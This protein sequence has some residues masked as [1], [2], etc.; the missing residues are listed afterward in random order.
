M[1]KSAEDIRVPEHQSSGL[2]FHLCITYSGCKQ[3]CSECVSWAHSSEHPCQSSG[4]DDSPV[5]VFLE[6]TQ[7]PGYPGSWKDWVPPVPT[8]P[9]GVKAPS[10]ASPQGMGGQKD[11]VPPLLRVPGGLK[12]PSPASPKGT[13][14]RKRL[15]PG[16]LILVMLVTT[17]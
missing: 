6:G 14:S 17:F 4:L 3:T 5:P 2:K 11:W 15:G 16:G 13:R 7:S 8:V 10:P 12:G 1:Y 9:G